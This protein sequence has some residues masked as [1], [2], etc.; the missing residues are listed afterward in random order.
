[1]NMGNVTYN[2]EC[3]AI[4]MRYSTER[5]TVQRMGRWIDFDCD[6]KALNTPFMESA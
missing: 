3:R 5:W 4:V 6:Y 2:A 1:M